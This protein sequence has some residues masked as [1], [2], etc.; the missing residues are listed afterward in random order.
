MHLGLEQ[1][2]HPIACAR[3]E[4]LHRYLAVRVLRPFHPEGQRV[5]LADDLRNPRTEAASIEEMERLDR[6]EGL[7][8]V[9]E[10]RVL[11][12]EE[13]GAQHNQIKAAEHKGAGQRQ[14]VLAEAPPDKGPGGGDRDALS[15]RP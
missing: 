12:A 15:G 13:V 4:E 9:G 2:E 5:A 3:R 10:L 8:R 14:I 6:Y 1:A 7:A 11:R